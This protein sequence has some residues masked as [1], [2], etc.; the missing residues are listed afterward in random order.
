MKTFQFLLLFFLIHINFVYGQDIIYKKN[1][2]KIVA[3]VLELN[4]SEVK[5][6]TLDNLDGPIYVV[7]KK[8]VS[9]ITYSN[10]TF[11]VIEDDKQAS[12][13]FEMN[14][15]YS[16]SVHMLDFMFGRLTLSYE[17][18][19]CKRRGDLGFS[20]PVSI[21]FNRNTYLMSGMDI[22][23]YPVRQKKTSYFIGPK[24][25]GGYDDGNNFL[26]GGSGTFL[27]ILANN[28]IVFNLENNARVTISAGVGF[29]RFFNQQ[30]VKPWG[31]VNINFG[32]RF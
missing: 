3:K 9:V 29:L 28:G 1:G 13:K 12:E 7:L 16:V 18:I 4:M 15:P 14:F 19:N 24:I 2:E 22:N 31:S 6:K 10:G 17:M 25:R 27:T 11:D 21:A 30:D 32:F 20:F 23:F 5:Y 8:D 26:S